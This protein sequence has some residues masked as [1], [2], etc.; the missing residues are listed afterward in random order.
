MPF[1]SFALSP[2]V[3]LVVLP[4][5]AQ[6]AAV[7][8]DVTLYTPGASCTITLTNDLDFGAAEKPATGSGSITINAQTGSR[9]SSGIVV[10][11]TS[12]VGQV[13][14]VGQH[15]SSYTMSRSFPTKLTK[16]TSSLDFTGAWSESSS[17]NSGYSSISTS[18][19]SGTAGGAG[20]SFTHHFRFGGQVSGITWSD[21]DGGYAGSIATSASCN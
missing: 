5:L 15:T 2:A 12:T 18:S 19:Y 3:L 21:G 1:R 11:G 7:D 17:A 9:S 16:G 13:R 14:L 4:A 20:T 8:V 6:S 10:S